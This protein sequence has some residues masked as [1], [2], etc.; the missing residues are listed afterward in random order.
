MFSDKIEKYIPP[1]KGKKHALRIIRELLYTKSSGSSTNIKEAF[2]HLNRVQ[3]KKSV[4]FLVSDFIWDNLP[5]KDLALTNNKH[6][7]TAIKIT[8]PLEISLP[9]IGL[10]EFEDA[11]TGEIILVDTG[12]NNLRNKYN[13]IYK[14]DSIN[15]KKIFRSIN[16][17]FIEIINGHDY[18]KQLLAYFRT[19]GKRR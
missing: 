1:K 9:D 11:E 15:I 17:D 4:V 3:K 7:L 10:I 12:N 13:S 6:D 16:A 5:E 18:F 8:D 2:E 14:T 19:R